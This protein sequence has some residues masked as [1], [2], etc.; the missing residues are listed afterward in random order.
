[1]SICVNLWLLLLCLSATAQTLAPGAPGKDAQWATAGK[2]AVGTSAN[3]ESKV[4]FTLAQGVMTEVYYPDVTVANVHLLQFVV[5]NPKTRK[6]ETEQDD[7]IHEIKVNSIDRTKNISPVEN[8]SIYRNFQSSASLA[9]T[10]ISRSKEKAKNQANINGLIIGGQ[11]SV[12]TITKNYVTNPENNS[13]V[14]SI[15]FRTD[16]SNNELYI[17]YDPSLANSGMGDTAWS[18]GNTLLA[19]DKEYFSALTCRF[20]K[21]TE[22]TNGF[23]GVNDG[24]TQLKKI[25]KIESFYGQAENG[26]VV[27]MAKI[28]PVFK[29]GNKKEFR[30]EIALGFGNSENSAVKATNES[31]I[32]GFNSVKE[33]Y[34]KEWIDYIKTLP[35]V[36][37]KYQ[38]QFNMAAMQLKALEDKTVRGANI[39]SLTVP[40]GGGDNAN[41]NNIGGYHL[42]WSRDLYQVFTAYM[43]L[44]DTAAAQRALDFLFKIQQKPDGSFPQNSYLD[45]KPFWGSL[46]MDEVAYPLIMAYQLGRFDKATWENHVKRAADFIVK[47]GPATP[48]ERWEEESGYSPSTIAAEIAGLVCAAEI[49]KAN[50]DLE[51]ANIYLKTADDW[52]ANID[53]WTVTTNGKLSELPYYVRITQNGTPDAGDKIELNNGAGT[54]D[55]RE[56]VDA[57]FLELV[58]LG[59]KSPD[60]PIIQNSVKVIDETIRVQTPN[61]DAFYRY[62]HDGYGEMDDGRRWNFDGKYTGKGRLWALL[63]GE[64]GQYEFAKCK[65]A[66]AKTGFVIDGVDCHDEATARWLDAMAKFSNEGLMIPE[67]IWDKPEVPKNADK[68]FV[69]ELKF[70]EGTG[71]ATPLA[72]SMAQFIRLAV[73]LQEGRNLDTPD[74]VYSRYVLGKKPEVG[75]RKIVER[76]NNNGA[77]TANCYN[78][79]WDKNKEKVLR[80]SP[81]ILDCDEELYLPIFVYSGNGENIQVVGDFT[82]WKPKNLN[83]TQY[84]PY[85]PVEGSFLEFSSYYPLDSIAPTARVEYKFIVDGKWIT[86]PLNP[87]KIDNGVGGENSY[88]E[89]PDYQPTVWDKGEIP[90]LETIEIESKIY[91]RR[92]IQ[93]YAPK[94]EPSAV[95]DGLTRQSE[96]LEKNSNAANAKR[97]PPATAGGSDLPTLY[98][99]DGTDYINRAKAVQIQQN[100]VEAGKIK[101]FI[102]VFLDPQDRTKEY[103]ANN[104]YSNFVAK[105]VVP[106]IDAKFNTIKSRD[107][108]A[109]MGASLGGITSINTAIKYP[110]IFGRI[111]G[112]SSS[113]WVDDERVVKEIEK[114]DASKN[115]FKFYIDDGTL[116]GVED[117]NKVVK[118]LKNKGYDVTYVEREAGHNWTAWRDRLADAFVALWKWHANLESVFPSPHFF[119]LLRPAAIRFRVEPNKNSARTSPLDFFEQ[120]YSGFKSKLQVD[121]DQR[122]IGYHR[123]LR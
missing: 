43:A 121:S 21:F 111:G 72:W 30:F 114:L 42:I 81:I 22:T 12:W 37:P 92:T 46:Q 91:G 122:R 123:N 10:Q 106:A 83:L 66:W 87:N 86:D 29:G 24:L 39:A 55:E 107:A 6:V 54:F 93:V 35:K 59:I 16:D 9:F 64:R 57:G 32:K 27:Q 97:K 65:M 76:I 98:L 19:K 50:N 20:C 4:W 99:Q 31:L 105:E 71:S 120:C 94:S 79:W 34:Q 15:E 52:Q 63:S 18:K 113:F 51:S 73:N 25:G 104:D 101:P 11:V 62:N 108:R 100:L 1:M 17:Y 47:N 26:N 89:M 67:Q 82:G 68:Q 74:V 36:E 96:N 119:S 23:L 2:Q 110:E 45:G 33:N 117:S 41:E 28:V 14:I 7:A 13:V 69:P 85:A 77:I 115:A 103:W 78:N 60:D 112:Q 58:R 8:L 84:Q 3:L 53:K 102:M 40:W 109:I 116:E 118:I 95:A 38:A 90:K 5:V 49:A 56:I 44:G 75:S 61:G 80:K 88:F 70:G 48:Q